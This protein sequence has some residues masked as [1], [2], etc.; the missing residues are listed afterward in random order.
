MTFWTDLMSHPFRVDLSPLCRELTELERGGARWTYD[1]SSNITPAMRIDD[2]KPSSLDPDTILD[3]LCRQL[4]QGEVDW[5]PF[6]V[7]DSGHA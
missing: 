3:R 2:G 5:N 7:T 4:E 6:E 1:G